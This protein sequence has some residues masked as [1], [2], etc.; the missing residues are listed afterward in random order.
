MSSGGGRLA[1]R[2]T[3]VAPTTPGI[4]VSD[5]MRV[6]VGPRTRVAPVTPSGSSATCPS[7]YPRGPCCPSGAHSTS[8]SSRTSGPRFP[9]RT[10]PAGQLPYRWDQWGPTIQ[11]NLVVLLHRVRWDQWN[12]ASV[13]PWGP[14]GPTLPWGPTGPVGP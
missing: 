10:G 3:N 7:S 12:R 14:R 5:K 6:P 9:S 1:N 8:G 11:S 13:S 4:S 2:S